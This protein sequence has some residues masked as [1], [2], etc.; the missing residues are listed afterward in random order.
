MH[1]F[2]YF[3]F[4]S[5]KRYDTLSGNC[6]LEQTYNVLYFHLSFFSLYFSKGNSQTTILFSHMF[7]CCCW[8][9]LH[10]NTHASNA[11]YP[12]HRIIIWFLNNSL[13]S[14]IIHQCQTKKY[15]PFMYESYG[16]IS[17]CFNSIANDTRKNKNTQR[18]KDCW[19]PTLNKKLHFDGFQIRCSL[20]FILF[21]FLSFC[22]HSNEILL[23]TKFSAWS[24]DLP[25]SKIVPQLCGILWDELFGFSVTILW[26]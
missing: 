10:K 19:Q 11:T 15:S 24:F 8:C 16:M 26:W 21:I 1:F 2:V 22:I 23:K 12:K 14:H 7:F 5:H 9:I 20:Y 13:W 6:F 17:T 4:C 18:L 25:H 3:F